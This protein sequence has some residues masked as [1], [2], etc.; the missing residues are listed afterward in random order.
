MVV[1]SWCGIG[2][3]WNLFQVREKSYRQGQG[4]RKDGTK[5]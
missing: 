4:S 1:H 2:G 5:F 3:V